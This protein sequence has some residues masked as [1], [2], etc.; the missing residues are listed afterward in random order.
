MVSPGKIYNLGPGESYT[1]F[2]VHLRNKAHIS[3]RE[4]REKRESGA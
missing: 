3:N 1:N 2:E 4:A